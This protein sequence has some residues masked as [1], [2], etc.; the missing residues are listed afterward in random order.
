MAGAALRLLWLG[1]GITQLARLR[2]KSRR[3][4]PPVAVHDRSIAWY[5]SSRGP[6]AFGRTILLPES[7][8]AMDPPMREAVALHELRHVERRDWWWVMGEELLRAAVWFHPAVWW[9]LR[10]IQATR[11]QVVDREVVE[12]TGDRTS[13]LEALVAVA[14]N[15]GRMACAPAPT[16]LSSGQ[17]AQRVAVVLKEA[18][19]SKKIFAPRMSGAVAVMFAVVAVMAVAWPFE[20]QAQGFGIPSGLQALSQAMPIAL[21]LPQAP[22]GVPG[23][24]GGGQQQPPPAVPTP[25][26]AP[27]PVDGGV[28]RVAANAAR[29]MLI[30]QALPVYPAAA[31]AARIQGVVNLEAWIDEQGRVTEVRVVDGPEPLRQ[32]AVDAVRQWVY[33]PYLLNGAPVSIVMEIPM[34]FKLN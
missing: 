4:E 9:A 27:T 2:R 21:P 15:G 7:V 32:A 29:G 13:Y 17:L 14:A 11:E 3:I 28:V 20:A 34:N 18:P 5:A 19:M 31:K 33:R 8:L 12:A 23:G 16:F 22:Q 10:R 26:P 30:S 1:L 25:A 6:A 24:R